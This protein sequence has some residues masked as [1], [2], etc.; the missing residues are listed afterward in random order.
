M[1]VCRIIETG[2]TPEQYDQ[3]SQGVGVSADNPPPGG[4]LHV[5]AKGD[6]GQIRIVDVWESREQAEEFMERVRAAREEA[7]MG[8]DEPQITYLE[9]HRLIQA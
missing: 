7:G 9:V 3:V 6:D 2:A 4:I 1:A 8:G 5:A